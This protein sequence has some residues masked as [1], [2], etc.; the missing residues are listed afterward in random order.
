MSKKSAAKK[1]FKQNLRSF[2]V[3]AI[4]TGL[5]FGYF[6]LA[7][8]TV[9]TLLGVAIVWLW[10]GWATW[11]QIILCIALCVLGVWASQEASTLLRKPDSSRI[12][13]DE[14]VGYMIAMVGIP[15]TPY[16][17]IWGFLLFRF[18]DIFKIPPANVFDKRM[19]NG[20]G[21]MLDD[22]TAG[23]YSNMVLH[24]MM[25]SAL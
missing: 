16:W 4:A 8:G 7:S 11:V 3:L 23:I 24:L 13:I 19:K 21:V 1:P 15:A 12:V 25:Q 17:I 14:V 20:W 2:A 6:P 22:V 5:F 9:G 18:F 10:Q